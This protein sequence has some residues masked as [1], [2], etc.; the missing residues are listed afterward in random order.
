[1]YRG[2]IQQS[3]GRVLNRTGQGLCW[4]YTWAHC[5][6]D[7]LWKNVVQAQCYLHW[8]PSSQTCPRVNRCAPRAPRPS[9]Y[10]A[11]WHLFQTQK[12]TIISGRKL[13]VKG[14]ETQESIKTLIVRVALQMFWIFVCCV[15]KQFENFCT[16][17]DNS[18]MYVECTIPPAAP[19]ANFKSN[20]TGTQLHIIGKVHRFVQTKR[21]LCSSREMFIHTF[22]T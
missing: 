22:V 11:P 1:M 15:W 6:V 4:R 2:R 12:I 18:F 21:L 19:S 16:P 9:R 13:I 3:A 8:T 10:F 17:K 7:T 20:Q 14:T 5:A